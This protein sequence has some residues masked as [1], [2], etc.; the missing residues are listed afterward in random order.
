MEDVVTPK[1]FPGDFKRHLIAGARRGDLTIREVADET[2]R[3]WMRQADIGKGIK[4]GMTSSK[5]SELVR[6]R[7][8]KRRMEL[9]NEILHRTASCIAASTLPK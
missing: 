9:G 5:Q 8:E 1:R 7:R 6:F 2:V 4:D 3:R